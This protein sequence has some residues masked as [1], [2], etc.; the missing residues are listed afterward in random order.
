MSRA[1]SRLAWG[2]L[3]IAELLISGRIVTRYARHNPPRVKYVV[4]YVHRL[5][6]PRSL[7]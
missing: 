3:D 4:R 5:P 2:L 1:A 6:Y 7:A